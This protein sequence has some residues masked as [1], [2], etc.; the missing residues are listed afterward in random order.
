MSSASQS[1]YV[2]SMYDIHT[3]KYLSNDTS[4]V[5]MA[6]DTQI[7][8]YKKKIRNINFVYNEYS[9]M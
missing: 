8:Q 7:L 1:M 4:E 9:K 6:V 3:Y 5:S 2:A